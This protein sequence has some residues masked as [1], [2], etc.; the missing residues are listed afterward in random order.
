MRKVVCVDGNHAK[1]VGL[2]QPQQ[3]RD[4]GHARL[5]LGQAREIRLCRL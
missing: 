1:R 3:R 2:A 4:L 5:R